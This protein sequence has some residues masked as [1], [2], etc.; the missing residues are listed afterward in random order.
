LDIIVVAALGNKNKI[1]ERLLKNDLFDAQIS[2]DAP[3]SDTIQMIFESYI[4]KSNVDL[5]APMF[6]I[7]SFDTIIAKLA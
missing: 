2:F 5:D 7:T 4:K 3:E 6:A 1:D